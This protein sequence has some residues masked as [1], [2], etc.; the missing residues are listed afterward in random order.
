MG[1]GTGRKR[2]GKRGGGRGE[3]EH[4]VFLTYISCSSSYVSDSPVSCVTSPR[5]GEADGKG[6]K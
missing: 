6:R 3:V 2:G 1:W 4:T 5:S